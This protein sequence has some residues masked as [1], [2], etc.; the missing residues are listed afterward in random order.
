[1]HEDGR[2]AVLERVADQVPDHALERIRIG[3]EL[4]VGIDLD[5]HVVEPV[6]RDAR[7]QRLD[8]IVRAERPR[9]HADAPGVEAREVEQLLGEVAQPH[10]LLEERLPQLVQLLAPRARP[11]RAD[12][13]L[14][15]PYTIAIGVRSSCE[16]IETN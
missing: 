14:A 13:V 8:G 11:P 9:V 15:I 12:I 10:A 6:G 5:P 4:D 3:D 2:R 7:Q 1:M 16:A